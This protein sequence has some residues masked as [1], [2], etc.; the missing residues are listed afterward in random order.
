MDDLRLAG[1]Q[2]RYALLTTFR[3]PRVVVFGMAFPIILLVLFNSIFTEGAHQTVS[4]AGGT[5]TASAYFTAG[6]AAY[7]IGLS[8]FTNLAV[9]VTTQRESGQL[10]RLRGTPMPGWTFIAGQVMRAGT[11]VS[12][13]V[14][15]MLAIGVLAYGV[16]PPAEH[17]VGFVVYAALG[18]LVFST[19]G[20][21]VTAYTPT[22]DSASTVGP[23]AMVLLSFVS[24]VFISVDQL[25]AWLEDVGSVFPLY[26]LANGLQ[27]ALAHGGGTALEWNHVAVLALWGLAGLYIATRQFRWELQAGRSD[28][29]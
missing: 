9:G 27:A 11:V 21:A 29:V 10:K 6:L 4:F 16:D 12:M 5:I 19:L 24:G 26:H 7:A 18:T 20:I 25:P 28:A 13:M 15:A 1:V 14:V 22:V 3:T 17:L 2:A 23:F 8:T